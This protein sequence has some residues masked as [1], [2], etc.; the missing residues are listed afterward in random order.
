VLYPT[1]KFTDNWSITAALQ[2]V[3]RPYFRESLS[4]KNYGI[5]DNILQGTLNYSLISDK[6]S[7]QIRVG[8]LSSAFG[9]FLLRYDDANNP[10]VGMPTQY[11]YYYKPVSTLG[12]AGAQ[13]DTTRH[14]WDGRLQV[15]NSSPANPRSIFTSDQYLNW[16]VGGGYAIRQGLRV[17]AS[18]YR[19][20]YL[21]RQYPFFFP[22]EGRPKSLPAHATGF[23]VEWARGHWNAQG[24]WQSFLM[25]YKL[26]PDFHE[27]AGY[28]EVKRVLNARWYVAQ[29]SGYLHSSSSGYS[30]TFEEAVGFR[31]DRL[32]VIKAGYELQHFHQGAHAL[33]NTFTVQLVTAFHLF[34]L[35]RN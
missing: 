17:G 7:L 21:Y 24:E 23:D 25:P 11:G 20:P 8:E 33:Q 10:L 19:G 14:K 31:P 13:I 34:S 32:Q 2:S 22:G 15:T 29:R 26:L 12:L 9:S 4:T 5:E 18:F 28:G 30:E 3:S 1:W 6:G 35:A 16:T 27:Q